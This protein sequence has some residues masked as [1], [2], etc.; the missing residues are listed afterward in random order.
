MFQVNWFWPHL[1]LVSF[2]IAYLFELYISIPLVLLFKL[3]RLAAVSEGGTYL[4]MFVYIESITKN[5]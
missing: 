2:L 3:V 4:W 1:V 5:Y